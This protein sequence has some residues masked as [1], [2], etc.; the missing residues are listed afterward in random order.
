MRSVG[1]Y[2]LPLAL[3]VAIGGIILAG[4]G[5]GLSR[6]HS[7]L[8][9]L[10]W[11]AVVLSILFGFGSALRRRLGVTL[12]PGEVMLAGTTV[13]VFAV[14]LLLPLG[15]AS[16]TPLLVLAGLGSAWALAELALAALSP[17]P[18]APGAAGEGA[19]RRFDPV[20]V[21]LL[22]LLGAY[23]LFNVAGSISTRGN[24]ADDG[25][26]YGGFIRRLLD[27]GDLVE[28]FSFRRL[29]AYG[30][31]TALLALTAMRGDFESFDLL[32]RGLY[33]VVAALVLL[34][35]ARRRNLHVA[36]CALLVAF[37]LSQME[38][39]FNS[40]SHWSGIAVFLGAYGV[41][42]REDLSPR[43]SLVGVYALCGVA[44][45]LR[46]NYLLPAGLFALFSSILHLRAQAAGAEAGGW[47]AAWQRERGTL[48]WGLVAAGV[49]VLPYMV[50]AWQSNRTFLYPVLAGTGNPV[51]PLRPIGATVFDE[52]IFFSGVLLNSE[53]VRSWWVVV[54][55]LCMVRDLRPRRPLTALLAASAIGFLYLTHSFMLSDAYNIW[56][57][58]AGYMTPLLLAFIV[59]MLVKLPLVSKAA[60]SSLPGGMRIKVPAIA[61]AIVLFLAL[62]QL[63]E[64]RGVVS[65]RLKENLEEVDAARVIG[66]A[67]TGVRQRGYREMQAAIPEGSHVAFLVDEA[68]HLDYSRHR[69]YNLDLPGFAAPAPGLPSFLPVPVWRDYFHSQGIRYLAFIDGAYSS[70]LYRRRTWATNTHSDHG[71]WRFMATHMVD[72]ID[73]LRGLAATS[74]VLYDQDGF[75]AVDLG[76]VRSVDAAALAARYATPELLREEEWLQRQLARELH[77]AMW[78]LMTRHDV[79]FDD[80]LPIEYTPSERNLW[81]IFGVGEALGMVT[82]APEAPRRWLI[83]RTHV[84]VLG[85]GQQRL[86]LELFIDTRR[87][88]THPTVEVSIDGR[89]LFTSKPTLDGKISVDVNAECRGWCDV[90]LM[91]STV[92]VTWQGAST[93][94]SIRLDRFAWTPA[95]APAPSVSAAGEASPP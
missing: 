37:L 18:A 22:V 4:W 16:R 35:L 29:S 88:G 46:Q 51:A 8:G 6:P 10:G 27:C 52:L 78:E 65:G 31:Q 17:A 64:S 83:D 62:V 2:R 81:E 55:L 3:A 85:H 7:L 19:Q 12:M 72:T 77:P 61:H 93:V 54:P 75:V 13:W 11:S 42:S 73:A 40:A 79:A 47:K 26:A 1:F 82:P 71:I 74:K 15:V 59:E 69:L 63:V 9:T 60:G 43:A 49:L 56:R 70:Y 86:Q 84:R 30:G 25:V 34:D 80:V 92:G 58:A 5:V 91:V 45:T 41:A 39:R 68:F 87:L 48:L 23:L 89:E 14:G 94:R 95:S 50:A 90:Y 76:P 38:N 66:A 32:D 57:Y 53:P 21:V 67:R 36:A 33:Q 44:C 24:P 20:V 28:P